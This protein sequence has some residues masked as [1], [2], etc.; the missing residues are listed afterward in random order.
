MASYKGIVAGIGNKQEDINVIQPEFDAI[1]RNFI[2]GQD[3]ILDGLE[4]KGN[5][6]TAG[7][8]IGKGFPGFFPK[9][10]TI[11][12]SDGY[13]YAAF[14]THRNSLIADDFSIVTYPFDIDAETS[15]EDILHKAGVYYFLLYE[16]GKKVV[17]S[18]YPKNALSSDYT[19]HINDNGTIGQNVTAYTYGI[20]DNSDKVS[21]TKYVYNQIKEE[22]AE[23]EYEAITT[24]NFGQNGYKVIR[25]AKYCII[26]IYTAIAGRSNIEGILNTLPEGFRPRQN[27]TI[28]QLSSRQLGTTNEGT[29]VINTEGN[30]ILSGN[31]FITTGDYLKTN[32]FTGGYIAQ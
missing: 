29:I 13:I 25:R 19:S 2:I 15:N 3:C 8:C 5:V 27:T 14:R 6:L 21:T 26:E 20:N 31:A 17:K 23:S 28:A 24:D 16:K 10:T 11:D 4:L 7:S 12:N 32:I 9:D 1:I 30:I 18:L 22:L